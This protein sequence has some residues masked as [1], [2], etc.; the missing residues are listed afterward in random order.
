[1]P[2][3][4]DWS[5][6]PYKL[7]SPSF[8]HWK[9]CCHQCESLHSRDSENLPALQCNAH[10]QSKINGSSQIKAYIIESQDHKKEDSNWANLCPGQGHKGGCTLCDAACLAAGVLSVGWSIHTMRRPNRIPCH[11]V[12]PHKFPPYTLPQGASSSTYFPGCQRGCFTWCVPAVTQ[13]VKALTAASSSWPLAW[14]CYISQYLMCSGSLPI[15]WCTTTLRSGAAGWTKAWPYTT[16]YRGRRE[17]KRIG[18]DGWSLR[19][20]VKHFPYTEEASQTTFFNHM[21]LHQYYMVTE[22]TCINSKHSGLF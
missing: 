9:F 4:L 18:F 17:T 19:V 16:P 20:T 8:S 21:L 10:Q 3:S 13:G 11:E 22:H 1:M 6:L 2:Q 12:V 7:P 5:S 14:C 15:C